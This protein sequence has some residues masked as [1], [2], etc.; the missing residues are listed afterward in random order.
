MLIYVFSFF[1][2][3]YI[4]HNETYFLKKIKGE[5]EK[6]GEFKELQGEFKH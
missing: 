4:F 1:Y 2:S 5:K 6:L 3:K